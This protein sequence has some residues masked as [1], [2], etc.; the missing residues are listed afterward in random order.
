MC[1]P[2]SET[3]TKRNYAQFEKKKLAFVFGA[4]KF[5]QYTNGRKV[6]FESDHKPLEVIHRKPLVAALKRLQRMLLRLQK[7]DLE[8]GFKPGQHTVL[9]GHSLKSASCKCQVKR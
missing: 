4:E 7:Y 3:D 5:N 9:S 1:F 2:I 8:I 6:Y